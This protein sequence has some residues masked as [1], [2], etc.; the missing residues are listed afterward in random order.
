MHAQLTK[1]LFALTV[2]LLGSGAAL[3]QT[4]EQHPGFPAESASPL[5]MGDEPQYQ[6]THEDRGRTIG[7]DPATEPT[8]YAEPEYQRTH[9]NK[10]ITIGPNYAYE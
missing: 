6:P 10:G 1:P 8:P 7:S 3:A 2:L 5:M 4:I 9:D